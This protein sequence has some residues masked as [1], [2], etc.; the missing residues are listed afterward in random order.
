MLDD[1]IMWGIYSVT[2]CNILVHNLFDQLTKNLQTYRNY[3]K[4]CL[5]LSVYSSEWETVK[6]RKAIDTFGD[7]K[8]ILNESYKTDAMSFLS[9]ATISFLILCLKK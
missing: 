2:T 6:K 3:P 4:R 9:S 8:I 1:H 5:N 7:Y